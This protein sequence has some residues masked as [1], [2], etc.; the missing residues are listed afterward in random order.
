MI[1]TGLSQS[2]ALIARYP[3]YPRIFGGRQGAR[4]LHFIGLMLLI[5]YV[6]SHLTMVIL[7]HFPRD[8]ETMFSMFGPPGLPSVA[9]FLSASLALLAVIGFHIAA[10]LYTRRHQ[11][12]FQEHAAKIVEPLM[13]F[14]FGKLTSR[15]QFD[16]R[17]VTVMHHVNGYPPE[18]GDYRGW[19]KPDF[20]TG[21]CASVDSSNSRWNSP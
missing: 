21:A 18:N 3:W 1:A 6:L 7:V 10:T 20:T 4:S 13:R 5:F 15:Q 17:N 12:S 14:F 9:A 11:R 2:P 19:P 8:V 16:R